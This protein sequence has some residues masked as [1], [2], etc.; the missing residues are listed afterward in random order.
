MSAVGSEAE[1]GESRP[2]RR[3]RTRGNAFTRTLIVV[4]DNGIGFKE[5][6]AA[7]IFEVFKRLH[8]RSDYAGSGIGLSICR[9]IAERHYGG[10]SA[11][12]SPGEGAEFRVILPVRQ[13][14]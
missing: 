13:A 7:A 1:G 9:R 10:I 5:E 8:G 12:S 2:L 4:K 6:H 11:H 14:K 3:V